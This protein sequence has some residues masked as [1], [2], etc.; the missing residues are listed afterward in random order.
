MDISPYEVA[1]EYGVYSRYI[2]LPEANATN[3]TVQ[4]AGVVY[5]IPCN[6]DHSGGDI[7][8]YKYSKP[9]ESRVFSDGFQGWSSL[10]PAPTYCI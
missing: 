4:P 9:D 5:T 10:P 1:E 3:N 8:T 2:Q 7:D 6:T